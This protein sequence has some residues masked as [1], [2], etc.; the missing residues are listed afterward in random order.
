MKKVIF[1]TTVK[2]N[3]EPAINGDLSIFEP[4]ANVFINASH[5]AA[6]ASYDRLELKYMRDGQILSVPIFP[7]VMTYSTPGSTTT[8]TSANAQTTTIDLT[9]AILTTAM[10]GDTYT[11]EIIHK[12]HAHDGRCRKYV[13]A[14]HSSTYGSTKV[15]TDATLATALTAMI[16]ELD[17]PYIAFT[18]AVGGTNNESIVITVSSGYYE[19]ELKVNGM[20]ELALLVATSGDLSIVYAHTGIGWTVDKIKAIEQEAESMLGDH[21]FNYK[22]D[23]FFNLASGYNVLCDGLIVFKSAKP[24]DDTLVL[25]PNFPQEIYLFYDINGSNGAAIVLSDVVD[26]LIGT[27]ATFEAS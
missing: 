9:G 19:E 17:M 11:L 22:E 27:D 25:E 10:A 1:A 23:A 5:S 12:G 3:A 13:S 4:T 7:K 16:N 24:D 6:A 26:W 14:V 2:L 21:N 15:T 8:F 18:A 20:N